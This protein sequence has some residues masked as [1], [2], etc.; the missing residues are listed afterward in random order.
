LEEFGNMATTISVKGSVGFSHRVKERAE[1]HRFPVLLQSSRPLDYACTIPLL[2]LLPHLPGLRVSPL[3]VSGEDVS[4][5]F[6]FGK[7]LREE[8]FATNERVAVIASANLSHR[9]TKTSPMGYHRS[10]KIFDDRI[11]SAL[12]AGKPD[13]LFTLSDEIIE[14]AVSCGLRPIAVLMGILYRRSFHVEALAYEHPHGVGYYTAA[15]HS[16]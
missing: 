10:G 9:L 12:E 14:D 5:H 8:I 11:R 6:E 7:M 4:S 3:I 15:L 2:S 1:D 13:E 16:S